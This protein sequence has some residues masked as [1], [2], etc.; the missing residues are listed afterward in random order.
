MV[1]GEARL[2]KRGIVE[3]YFTLMILCV[4]GGESQDTHVCEFM[5]K[6]QRRLA[7]W[8]SAA[9]ALD[10]MLGHDWVGYRG[11]RNLA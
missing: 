2:N 11:Q 9:F 8:I 3:R 5:L 1:K 10:N 6:V 7:V 4:W